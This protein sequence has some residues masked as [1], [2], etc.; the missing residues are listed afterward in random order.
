MM[1]A[2]EIILLP[3]SRVGAILHAKATTF[4][5]KR[6]GQRS[7]LIITLKTN[8]DEEQMIIS[9]RTL[10]HCLGYWEGKLNL[11]I[12][13]IKRLLLQLYFIFILL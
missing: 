3:L 4:T 10:K 5:Q 13:A 7:S 12:S 8:R 11:R 6:N 9:V 2:E 1:P